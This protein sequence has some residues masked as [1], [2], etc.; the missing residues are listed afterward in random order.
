MGVVTC[1]G[2]C[3]GL[4]SVIRSI[5]ITA[6]NGYGVNKVYGFR[7]GYAGLNPNINEPPTLLDADM[8]DNIHTMGGTIL[9]SS[10][11]QQPID[12][13][14]DYLQELGVNILCVIGGDGTL[15]GAEELAK[16]VNARGL[17]ISI[18]GV[19]KTIDNDIAF[20]ER[21]FGFES[22]VQMASQVIQ[23]AHAESKGSPNGIGLVKLMGRESGFITATTTLSSAVV[24]FCLIPEVKFDLEGEQ[25]LLK[26]LEERI[27]RR[28]H[29]VIAVAEGAGQELFGGRKLG[30]DASGNRRQHDI[31]LFLKQ[32]IEEHFASINLETNI[33]YIDPSY[34]IRS[35]PANASDN[36]YCAMLG[37][38]A[39]HAGMSG[40]TEMFVAFR[41]EHYVSLP[42]H[43]A[44]GGRRSVNPNGRLWQTVLDST[45]Q[46]RLTNV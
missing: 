7:N 20:I 2:L 24:N 10:R 15:R 21:S 18:I 19:P 9:G 12:V 23:S 8:V 34:L 25:G 13:M 26:K 44:T 31:G 1:G 46:P 30:C 16:E 38:N 3:P 36:I 29:A 32:K 37:Q 4:N 42:M 45:Y 28:R 41:N 11:G 40:C 14:V 6:I 22:A 27:R 43:L 33:K 39:V 5:V 17:K 35:V